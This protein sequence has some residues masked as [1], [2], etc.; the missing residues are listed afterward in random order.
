[1]S[2]RMSHLLL[3]ALVAAFAVLAYHSLEQKSVTIDEYGYLPAAYNLVSTGDLRFSEWHTPLVNRLLGLPLIGADVVAPEPPDGIPSEG[4]T[5]FWNNGKWF[6]E[7][8]AE[9]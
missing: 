3:L 6:A 2:D 9:R 8:N 5:W 4:R 1:M 7:A